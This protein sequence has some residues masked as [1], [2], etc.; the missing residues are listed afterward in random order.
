MLLLTWR[1]FET[2]RP[3]RD[4]HFELLDQVEQM[5]RFP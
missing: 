4:Q 3:Q 1:S 5:V 2:V